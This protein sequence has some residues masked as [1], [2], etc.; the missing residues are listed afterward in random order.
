MA[1]HGRKARAVNVRATFNY[2]YYSQ[3]TSELCIH[4][5][6]WAPDGELYLRLR[7]VCPSAVQV[8]CIAREVEV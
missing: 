3:R 4:L 5:V 2:T 1:G 8:V 7:F 6:A